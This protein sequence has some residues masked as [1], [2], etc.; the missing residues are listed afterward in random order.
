MHNA[1]H[2]HSKGDKPVQD[3]GLVVGLAASA[4][5]VRASQALR[6]QVFAVEMGAKVDGE[7]EQL[8]VDGYDPYCHHLLVRDQTTGLVVGSTRMLLDL[9]AGEAGGFY[10]ESEFDIQAIRRLSGRFMEIGRTCIHPDYRNGSAIGVLW[11]GLAQFMAMHQID[12]M[13]GCAS[14]GMA[15][16]GY[17]AHAIMHR[18]RTRF[19][20]DAN[21][22][23]IPKRGLPHLD[24]ELPT[25][26][27]LPPLLKAYLHV[28]VQICGE[29]YW[30]QAFNVADVFVLLDLDKA[31]PRYVR[32][33]LRQDA[34]QR[35]M[36]NEATQTHA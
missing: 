2:N 8:D 30:D 20:S 36:W 11:S 35:T 26:I 1:V 16:G 33:F 24:G 31:N 10:S 29:P 13:M 15:D 9:D 19:M 21:L 14:I 34:Y 28:G 22:R 25:T 12:Y 6:Y 32:H 18:L 4:A 3:R 5:E 27:T 17:Q 23:V 7:R